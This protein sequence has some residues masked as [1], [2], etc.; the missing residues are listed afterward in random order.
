MESSVVLTLS[1]ISGARAGVIT[2]VLVNRE[3]SEYPNIETISEAEDN[4]IEVACNAVMQLI[5]WDRSKEIQINLPNFWNPDN[6][7]Q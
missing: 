4:A 2:G 7:S 1:L 3:R 5:K 6:K